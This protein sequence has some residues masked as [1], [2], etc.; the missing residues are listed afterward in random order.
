MSLSEAL[1]LIIAFALSVY[2]IFAL[3]RGEKF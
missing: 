1:T 2:L 3:L